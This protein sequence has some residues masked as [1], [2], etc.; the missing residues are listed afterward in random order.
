MDSI[1]LF[2]GNWIYNKQSRNYLIYNYHKQDTVILKQ[3]LLCHNWK[4]INHTTVV[5]LR[6]NSIKITICAATYIDTIQ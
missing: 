5:V 6:V 2:I 1:I 3:L 4:D